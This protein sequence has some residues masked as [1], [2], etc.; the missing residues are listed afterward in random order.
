MPALALILALVLQGFASWQ[1]DVSFLGPGVRIIPA[2]LDGNEQTRE[3]VV[4]GTQPGTPT[5]GLIAGVSD[6][7]PTTV[8]WFDPRPLPSEP[9]LTAPMLLRAGRVDR[10]IFQTA[11]FYI[12]VTIEVR[13]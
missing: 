11:R 7:C 3:W 4:N 9:Y 1:V 12:E 6:R 13:C 5:Y 8:R 10:A 2:E